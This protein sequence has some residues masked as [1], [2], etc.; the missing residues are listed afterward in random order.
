MASS[1]QA[2]V[3]VTPCIEQIRGDLNAFAQTLSEVF[4]NCN[5]SNSSSSNG[6]IA[7]AL[8]V[9]DKDQVSEKTLRNIEAI[10]RVLFNSRMMASSA[11]VVNRCERGWLHKERQVANRQLRAMLLL[12]NGNGFELDL[13]WDHSSDD[14]DVLEHN[15][16]VC[17]E[18]FDALIAFLSA[19]GGNLT[20]NTLSWSSLRKQN[21]N[22][23]HG[24]IAIPKHVFN[25]LST[26]LAF[27]TFFNIYHKR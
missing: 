23:L 7:Y 10:Q 14:Q 21:P 15:R 2:F 9:I 19:A 26:V 4:A 20:A 25:S 12:C 1:D 11:L 27:P 3:I 16:R 13:K 5:G 18:S 22:L 6:V 17:Q 24:L 8:F